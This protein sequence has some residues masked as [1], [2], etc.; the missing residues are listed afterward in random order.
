[1]LGGRS[2]RP[3]LSMAERLHAEGL[4]A[5][6]GWWHCTVKKR[7]LCLRNWHDVQV[8][9][10]RVISKIRGRQ[11]NTP[12]PRGGGDPGICGLDRSPGTAALSHNFSPNRTS[13]FVGVERGVPGHVLCESGPPR[14]S[15][16][17]RDWPKHQLRASRKR[18]HQ[19]P[20][21]DC[22][23]AGLRSEWF[24]LNRIETTFVSRRRAFIS[25]SWRGR[26]LIPKFS[27]HPIERVGFSGIAI[28]A[29]REF[30]DRR[31]QSRNA[32][33]GVGEV[34]G[35][36]NLGHALSITNSAPPRKLP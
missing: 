30:K 28:I 14:I 10:R 25:R 3:A 11:R 9:N 33:L 15:P 22:L 36:D 18:D 8:F 4:V 7:R 21:R 19:L 2:S 31:L 27:N 24:V 26:I 34:F 20:A 1:M 5:A 6:A 12:L 29:R 17:V 35:I 13:M 23:K 16:S 32:D